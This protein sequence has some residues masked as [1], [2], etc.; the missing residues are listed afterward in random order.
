MTPI[1][2]L[3]GN[4]LMKRRN[5]LVQILLFIVTFG[6]YGIYWFYA[7]SKEMVE[8]KRLAGSPI[9]WTILLFIPFGSFFS[10]WK[11]GKAIVEVTD[12]KYPF[13]LIYV[14][15]LL[16]NPAVWLLTQ[17]ELNKLAEE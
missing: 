15:W 14:L 8:Y 6:M 10:Y 7:T 5:R 1:I 12:S 13:L 16:F 17:I 4:A 9:L 2:P 3:R 11:H